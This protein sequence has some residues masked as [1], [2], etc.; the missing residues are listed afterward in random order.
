MRREWALS[1]NINTKQRQNYSK[2]L[3]SSSG[4]SPPDAGEA[5][6]LPVPYKAERAGFNALAARATRLQ[7][8]VGLA[9]YALALVILQ[10]RQLNHV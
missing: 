9:C 1:R 2:G 4:I 5:L 6:V 7:A 10:A 3:I 8:L